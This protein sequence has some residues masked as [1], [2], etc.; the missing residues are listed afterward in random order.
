MKGFWVL[1]VSAW[2]VFFGLVGCG[3]KLSENELPRPSSRLVSESQAFPGVVAIKGSEICTGTIVGPSTVLTAAHC[4]LKG[5]DF[6]VETPRGIL[7]P[8]EVRRLGSGAEGDSYDIALIY[9][10]GPV[11]SSQDILPLASGIRPGDFVYLV[12]FGCT[13]SDAKLSTGIKRL[14]TNVISDSNEFIEVST[15]GFNISKIVGPENRAG[16]CFGD[17]GGPLLKQVENRWMV[18]GVAHGAYNEGS[19]QISQFVNLEV[20]A[21]KSFLSQYVR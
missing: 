20:S 15:P 11:F 17:S 4:V 8:T 13:S 9:F 6:V 5:L 16:L 7:S 3:K 18:V 21:T 1:A 14:G 12:G 19:R 2:V 10:S